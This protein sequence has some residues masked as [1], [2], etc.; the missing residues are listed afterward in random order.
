MRVIDPGH[1]YSLDFL[2]ADIPTVGILR[3]VKRIGEG[4]P[5][6]NAPSHPGTIIQE[7]LRALID[8]MKYVRS[9]A[10][11]LKDWES[12]SD[13][14]I[15]I[16][17]LRSILLILEDRAARRHGRGLAAIDRFAPER[18]PTCPYCGHTGCASRCRRSAP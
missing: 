3:F 2:D 10:E 17:S 5:G 6:N 1:E 7:V 4:Y 11:A 16:D 14:S 15:I 12:A 18:E 8:R 13:D 9:Q